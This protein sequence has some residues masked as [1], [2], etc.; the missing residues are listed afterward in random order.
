MAGSFEPNERPKSV[1][2]STFNNGKVPQTRTPS[3]NNVICENSNNFTTESDPASAVFAAGEGTLSK[4][5]L[6]IEGN[7]AGRHFDDIIVD[8][9]S[10]V[11]L[12]STSLWDQLHEKFT[13]THVKSK[14]VVANGTPLTVEGST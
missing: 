14:Y 7:L 12:I 3:F 8:T 6:A 9:G 1:F 4:G 2:I 10:A 13:C 5:I 11:S